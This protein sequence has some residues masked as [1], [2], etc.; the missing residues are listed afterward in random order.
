MRRYTAAE[1]AERFGLKKHELPYVMHELLDGRYRLRGYHLSDPTRPHEWE[2]EDTMTELIFD[3]PEEEYF[4]REDNGSTKVRAAL[5]SPNH[6]RAACQPF[7]GT[8]S[9]QLGTAIH[10]AVLE[11]DVFETKYLTE[12]PPFDPKDLHYLKRDAAKLLAKGFKAAGIAEE[13]GN[14]PQTVEGYLEID[15]VQELA[16]WYKQYG[17]DDLIELPQKDLNIVRRVRDNVFAHPEAHLILDVG[18]SEVSAFAE[19]DGIECKGRFDWRLPG[20]LW[21]IKSS[22]KSA[23][24]AGV[25]K[26]IAFRDMHVQAALYCELDSRCSA[27]PRPD[28]GWLAVETSEPFN[29]G[30]YRCGPQTME[31]GRALMFQ[32]LETIAELQEQPG[33][34]GGYSTKLEMLELPH[35]AFRANADDEDEQGELIPEIPF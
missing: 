6:Y 15:Q 23:T 22:W 18:K 8:R 16:A 14:K 29:V 31:E 21:D 19:I 2:I 12:Q 7:D 25:S 26:A 35:W 3:M 20:E 9:T 24:P 28:F 4:A 30:V 17:T 10:R 34:F 5:K 33:M 11:P 1:I 27:G 13:M 32:A